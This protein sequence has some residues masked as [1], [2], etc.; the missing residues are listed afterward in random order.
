MSSSELGF[1]E[2]LKNGEQQA[3]VNAT[4]F[5]PQAGKSYKVEIIGNKAKRVR[6]SKGTDNYEGLSFD[7]KVEGKEKTWR[8]FDN[9]APKIVK[10]VQKHPNRII[11]VEGVGRKFEAS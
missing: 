5:I 8:V 6:W 10:A 7:V 4:K 1:D 9:E 2:I 11:T 3:E